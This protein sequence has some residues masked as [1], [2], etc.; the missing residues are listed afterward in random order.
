MRRSALIAGFLL[1]ASCSSPPKPLEHEKLYFSLEIRREGKL[2]AKPKFVGE[3]GKLARLERRQPGATVPEY[4]LLVVPKSIGEGY[5][6]SIELT[7]PEIQGSQQVA[8]LHGQVRQLEFSPRPG[9]LQLS[10]LLMKVDSPEFEVMMD[11]AT[12]QEALESP[13]SI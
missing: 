6:V 11:L 9:T 7:L 4:Q 13:R 10:L 5:Q 12:R 1:L 8:L 3:T 2:V